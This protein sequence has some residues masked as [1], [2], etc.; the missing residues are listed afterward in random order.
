MA[1]PISLL[2]RENMYSTSGEGGGGLSHAAQSGFAQAGAAAGGWGSILSGGEGGNTAQ[3][4][5]AEEHGMLVG[6]QTANA[7]A[8]ARERVNDANQRETAAKVMEGPEFAQATGLPS[9]IASWGAAQTRAGADPAKIGSFMLDAQHYKNRATI[10]ASEP[11]NPALGAAESENPSMVAPK[12]VGTAGSYESPQ[13]FVP[14]GPSPVHISDQQSQEN[15]ATIA[16]KNHQANAPYKEPGAAGGKLQTGFQWDVDTDMHSPT[17][18]QV[19]NNPD[20]TPRQVPNPTAGTGEG[21]YGKLYHENMIGAASG[22]IAELRNLMDLGPT[23]SVGL[24]NVKGAPHGMLGA[25]TTDMGRALST[26]TQQE[27]KKSFGNLGRFIA[28]AENGGRPPPAGTVSAAQ[29]QME[30]LPVDTQ[31]ARA[32]GLALARQNLEAT[33]PRVLASNASPA[34]KQEYQK[35][36]E[37]YLKTTVP[38]LPQDIRDWQRSAQ[39]GQSIGDFMKSKNAP[40]SGGHPADIQ[41]LLSKYPAGGK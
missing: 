39:Q 1:D 24:S 3:T 17:Y 8:Q 7:M 14:G 31:H 5:Q 36:I 37:N 33:L 40:Q 27:V 30:S 35:E 21:A 11:N 29:E 12:A 10:A 23:E 25:L 34:I 6:A 28:T 20:G 38:F 32:Y 13:G 41:D 2:S 16:E 18:G 4:D 9:A 22:A 15:Q 26:E 19:R